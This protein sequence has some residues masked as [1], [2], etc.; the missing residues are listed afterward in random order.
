MRQEH[1]FS[2]NSVFIISTKNQFKKKKFHKSDVQL[3]DQSN[4]YQ[5][6]HKRQS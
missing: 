5:L 1:Y 4:G 2:E 3:Q 6:K